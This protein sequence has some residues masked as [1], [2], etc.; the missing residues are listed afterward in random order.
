MSALMVAQTTDC[1][2]GLA[3]FHSQ[4]A[5]VDEFPV[6]ACDKDSAADDWCVV[7]SQTVL[8][9][10]QVTFKETGEQLFTV[11]S[12]V[13]VGD[14]KRQLRA[15]LDDEREFLLCCD[16]RGWNMKDGA[17]ISLGAHVQVAYGDFSWSVLTPDTTHVARHLARSTVVKSTGLES[18]DVPEISDVIECCMDKYHHKVDGTDFLKVHDALCDK[19]SK[20][21]GSTTWSCDFRREH[22][23]WPH[24]QDYEDAKRSLH[25]TYCG[26][27]VF[28]FDPAA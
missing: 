9:L 20:L 5:G 11:E 27:A 25:A 16:R 13:T 2:T 22:S 24:P 28:V 19:L 7:D 6:E 17:W 12:P 3:S 15:T 1:A 26:V 10:T 4:M 23:K 8:S 18:E 21:D 14:V